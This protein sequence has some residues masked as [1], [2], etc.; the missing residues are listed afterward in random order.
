MP[1][2]PR[3]QCEPL[4]SSKRATLLPSVP[5][6]IEAGFSDSEFEFWVGMAVPRPSS[7]AAAPTLRAKGDWGA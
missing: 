3:K 4:G 7:I 2:R 1:A 6:T 5:T